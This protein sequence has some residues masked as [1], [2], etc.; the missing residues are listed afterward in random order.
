[1][2]F[3]LPVVNIWNSKH[4]VHLIYS[5]LTVQLADT[6]CSFLPDDLGW[7]RA[8]KFPECCSGAQHLSKIFLHIVCALA[9]GPLL[10]VCCPL[11]LSQVF[12]EPQMCT[13]GL[14]DSSSPVR[15]WGQTNGEYICT[16]VKIMKHFNTFNDYSN[17]WQAICRLCPF[18]FN[19]FSV[20]NCVFVY[21][22]MVNF[23]PWP[24]DF[25]E[26]L[27]TAKPSRLQKRRNFISESF[28]ERPGASLQPCLTPISARKILFSLFQL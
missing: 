21:V 15:T 14:L 20:F 16:V 11:V 17:T 13:S 26:K 23:L 6:K 3:F 25:S 12:E 7:N 24:L 4:L 9:L 28:S 18:H 1:M 5:S 8:S 22:P 27:G 2:L 19:I 10:R